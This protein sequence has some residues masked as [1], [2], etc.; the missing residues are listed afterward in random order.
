M[1]PFSEILN[2]TGIS[3][4]Y[5]VVLVFDPPLICHH[6]PLSLFQTSYCV[7]ALSKCCF[8][9]WL[10]SLSLSSL[11]FL[12]SLFRSP[13]LLLTLYSF[14]VLSPFITDA[15]FCVYVNMLC[16]HVLLNGCVFVY[17]IEECWIYIYL[18][19]WK[20]LLLYS[21]AVFCPLLNILLCHTSKWKAIFFGC[22][23]SFCIFGTRTY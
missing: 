21:G 9:S 18:T 16:M 4:P 12:T 14:L 7:G 8:L 15:F 13:L 1:R 3:P 10:L 11:F 2:W 17:C 6:S 20:E 19:L 23:I 5:P 22:R